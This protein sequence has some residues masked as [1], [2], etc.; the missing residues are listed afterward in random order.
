MDIPYLV[1]MSNV[2]NFSTQALTIKKIASL[3]HPKMVIVDGN[4]LGTGLIDEL[5]KETKD[6]ITG[7]S[8]GCWDTI[9]TDNEPEIKGAPKCVYDIKA[10]GVQSRILTI[11]M[12]MV[13]SKKLRLLYKRD[14][15][16]FTDKE[17]TDYAG[18]IMPFIQTDL[19]FEEIGNL[20]LKHLPSGALAVERVVRKVDKDRFSALA[21]LLYYVVEFTSN[22]RKRDQS[23]IERVVQIRAPKRRSSSF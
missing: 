19:L 20:K 3:Y 21:Y 15:Q 13:D 5:L 12:D 10:Q 17:R 18:N 22:Y 14:E 4:G 6:P 1:N 7:E 9:N 11:F 23:D 16:D 2:L 8:Y